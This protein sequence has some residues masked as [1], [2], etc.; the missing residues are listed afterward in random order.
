MVKMKFF[1]VRKYL[2]FLFVC[3]AC[4]NVQAQTEQSIPDSIQAQDPTEEVFNEEVYLNE[5]IEDEYEGDEFDIF[6]NL[7]S[8]NITTQIPLETFARNVSNVRLGL[9]LSYYNNFSKKDDLFWA[10]HFSNFG[11][12]RLSNTIFVQEQFEEYELFSRTKT[13][14]YF[15]GYGMRYYPDFYTPSLEPY[16]DVKLGANY[17]ATYTSDRIN[18]AEDADVSFNNSD[19]SLAYAVGIGLQYNVRVGQ[20]IHL[21]LNYHGGTNATYYISEEKG[22][23]YPYDNFVRRTTQLDYLQIA[24]GMTFG[25]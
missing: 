3:F 14:L 15:L 12:D 18:D 17:I 7:V 23:E 24:A 9:G 25:F 6:I 10:I 11:I 22:L 21:S 5:Y 1:G 2:F 8:L 16:L 4:A 13:S 20:A 19:V